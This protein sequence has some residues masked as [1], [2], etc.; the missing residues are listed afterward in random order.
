MA[1]PGGFIAH[2][3]DYRKGKKRRGQCAFTTR[4]PWRERWCWC[5]GC[6]VRTTAVDVDGTGLGGRR[7]RERVARDERDIRYGYV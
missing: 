4:E 5:V 6:R 1:G 2:S 7:A 3:G